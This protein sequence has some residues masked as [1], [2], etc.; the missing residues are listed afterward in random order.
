MAK[1][2]IRANHSKHVIAR[3]KKLPEPQC[4][5]ILTAVDSVR[6]KIRDA[7]IFDW[8]PAEVH[9]ELVHHVHA[10]LPAEALLQFWCDLV[11]DGFSRALLKPLVT[12]GLGVYGKKPTSFLRLAPHAWNLV[13][14]QCGVLTCKPQTEGITHMA[15]TELPPVIDRSP[16]M[17]AFVEGGLRAT[18]RYFSLSGNVRQITRTPGA[19]EFSVTYA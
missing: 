9:L 17:I 13:T 6:A 12:G 19:V 5:Q 15:L 7:G 14:R 11:L 18:Y 4:T 3:I 8:Y 2:E 10:V 1:S 16:G